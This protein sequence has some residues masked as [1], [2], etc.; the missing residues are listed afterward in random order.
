[1]RNL[2]TL[3]QREL[4]VGVVVP[5]DPMSQVAKGCGRILEDIDF[6]QEVLKN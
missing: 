3:I 2:N 4:K 5:E 1:L 6:Y